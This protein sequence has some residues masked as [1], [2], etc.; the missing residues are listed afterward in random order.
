MVEL[1]RPSAPANAITAPCMT[2]HTHAA[3]ASLVDM[4][5]Q[6]MGHPAISSDG[7]SL[8]CSRLCSEATYLVFCRGS[9]RERHIV[10]CPERHPERVDSEDQDEF[11]VRFRLL[12]DR[13][14]WRSR[15][16]ILYPA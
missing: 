14:V 12:F 1:S 13:G 3:L 4:H 8:F 9:I 15:R 7:N 2:V 5:D 11:Q 10:Q 16:D 6:R